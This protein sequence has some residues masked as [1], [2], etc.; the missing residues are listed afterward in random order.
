MSLP[1]VAIVGRPN[2]GKSELF[3]RLIGRRLAIVEETPRL[4]RDRLY[5]ECQ[6]DGRSFRLADTGGLVSG[7]AEALLADV[8]RQTLRAIEEADVLLM[9]VDARAGPLPEDTEVAAVLREARKPVLLVAN[10]VD[11]PKHTTAIYEFHALGLGE[12]LAVSARHGLGTGDL[13]DEVVVLLPEVGEGEG[14]GE[15]TGTRVA[16]VGRPNVGKSSLVNALLGEERVVVAASP[17]TTRDAV[18]THL[19]F[20]GRSFVLVDT[21]GLRRP[22]RVDGAIERYSVSRTRMAIERADVAIL[23]LD[24]AQGVADQDQHIARAIADAGRGLTVALNKWDLIEDPRAQEQV[25][26]RVRHGLRFVP[27]ASLVPVSATQATGIHDLLVMT[28]SVADA[29]A[30][31]I[32]TGPLNRIVEGATEA[33]PPPADGQGRHV[34]ILYATQVAASPPTCVLFVNDPAL[35]P[36]TY[37]RYLERTLREAFPFV[38]VPIRFVLRGRPQP[39]AR[40]RPQPGGRGRPRPTG[41]A[42]GRRERTKGH[43]T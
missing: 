16:V 41:R 9:V 1:V 13:L 10:K 6:W 38:G 2:V 28:G 12:P 25:R 21:A 34:R 31:R 23:V 11:D 30:M 26:R 3:N 43:R 22:S 4:T 36:A 37:L 27:Y 29:Y 24:A 33:T 7:K 5:A 20:G 35:M 18:D 39:G 8:R 32:A 15:A 40:G 14:E 42:G 17:G 19:E